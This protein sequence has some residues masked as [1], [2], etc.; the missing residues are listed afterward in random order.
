MSSDSKNTEA[1]E[2]YQKPK[3]SIHIGPL[4]FGDDDRRRDP[5]GN[6]HTPMPPRPP[7]PDFNNHDDHRQG[8]PR[9]D[10][11][12]P[13]PHPVRDVVTTDDQP[14][15]FREIIEDFAKA[16]HE[17][18]ME[19][20]SKGQTVA[21]ENLGDTATAF[22]EWHEITEA[23]REGRRSQARWLLEHYGMMDAKEIVSDQ[24]EEIE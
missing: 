13:G 19:A 8:P 16:I 10:W 15:P 17:S 3:W 2:E 9:P 11:R 5:H 20:V 22:L 12:R 1:F 23:A 24:V 14:D 18:G 4:Y 6:H 7:R 21:F